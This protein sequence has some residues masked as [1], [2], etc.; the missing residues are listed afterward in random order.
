MHRSP[1]ALFALLFCLL[2]PVAADPLPSKAKGITSHIK[3]QPVQSTAI[4]SVG[5]SKRLRALEIE[6]KTGATYRYLKVEPAIHRELL[7]A[8]SKARYYNEHI[9]RKYR[10]LPVRPKAK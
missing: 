10:S 5:Y 7:N 1:F 8:P 4:A 3:R 9:R 2:I 6:F